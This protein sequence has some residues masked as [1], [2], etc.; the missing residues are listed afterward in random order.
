MFEFENLE[1]FWLHVEQ[2]YKNFFQFSVSVYC[3]I[4]FEP[5]TGWNS[6]EGNSSEHAI[7][8]PK[9]F[10]I[11]FISCQFVTHI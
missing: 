8:L 2:I 5:K 3:R 9:E 11:I 7:W 6:I 4:E 1:A 10:M